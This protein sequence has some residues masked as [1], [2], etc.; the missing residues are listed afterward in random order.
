MNSRTVLTSL[1][2]AALVALTACTGSTTGDPKPTPNTGGSTSSED[3]RSST[4][5]PTS[6]KA[7]G[8]LADTDPCSLLSKSEAEQV[9]GTLKEEPKPEKIGSARGCDYS[10]NLAGFSVDIRTNV[11]LAGVQAPGEVTDVTIGR[12]QA[13]KFVAAGGSCIVAV[14]VTSSSRVDVTLN[15]Q[16]DP[17]PR[18]LQIAELVEPKLP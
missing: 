17:C 4:S 5:S 3:T 13:K 6:T 2:A 16:G 15:G 18:A 1:A 10:A 14:G 11:G 9:M 12:H 8:S 7:S